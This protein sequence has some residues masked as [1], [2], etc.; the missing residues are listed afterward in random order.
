MNENG[1]PADQEGWTAPARSTLTTRFTVA[2]ST[3]LCASMQFYVGRLRP[4]WFGRCELSV[5]IALDT[6]LYGS[7]YCTTTDV[8]ELHEGHLSFPSGHTSFAFCQGVEDHCHVGHCIYIV[9]EILLSAKLGAGFSQTRR[10][11]SPLRAVMIP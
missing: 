11:P 10:A 4:D 2:W 5:D 1:W 9:I 7:Q 8:H 6:P 3:C